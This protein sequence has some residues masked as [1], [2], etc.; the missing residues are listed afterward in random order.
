MTEK[1]SNTEGLS[2]EYIR[3]LKPSSVLYLFVGVLIFLVALV[4]VLFFENMGM[5]FFI[6]ALIGV[7][8]F[9]LV[10]PLAYMI[11]R[12]AESKGC[13]LNSWFVPDVEREKLHYGP[14]RAHRLFGH[15]IGRKK[16]F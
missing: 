13:G 2:E 6:T 14:L 11:A 4:I 10:K 8:P 5:V 16:W 12:K 7:T 15:P 3:L 1:N 9:I